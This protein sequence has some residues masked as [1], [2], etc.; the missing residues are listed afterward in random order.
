MGGC[1]EKLFLRLWKTLWSWQRNQRVRVTRAAS[2]IG[3]SKISCFR[4]VTSPEVMGL[5]AAPSMGKSLQMRTSSC[6]ITELAGC[7]WQTLGR[8]PMITVFHHCKEDF[9]AG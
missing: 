6:S 3:L 5:V 9:L 8:T 4:E 7:L 1:L 2:S